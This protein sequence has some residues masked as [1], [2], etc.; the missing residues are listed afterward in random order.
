M[1]L[2]KNL[3]TIAELQM[4][5]GKTTRLGRFLITESANFDAVNFDETIHR[6]DLPQPKAPSNQLGTQLENQPGTNQE[7]VQN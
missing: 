5:G 7:Y 4:T 6:S 1:K 3:K 2:P